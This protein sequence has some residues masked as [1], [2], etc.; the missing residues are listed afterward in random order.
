MILKLNKTSIEIKDFIEKKMVLIDGFPAIQKQKINFKNS[1]EFNGTILQLKTHYF[2]FAYYKPRGTESTMNKNIQNNLYDAT[3]IN[4][5][6]FPVGR[7]DI[8]SEGLMI[9]TN[10][11]NFY[12]TIISPL[13]KVEKEYLVKVDKNVTKEFIKQ[14]KS[15]VV[16][17]GRKTQKCEAEKMGEFD[18][19]I[20]LTEGKNRQIRRMCYKLGFEVLQLKR[21]RIGNLYLE[22]LSSGEFLKIEKSDI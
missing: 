16:I 2:Y 15:G 1:I 10:D 19:K 12:N 22:N 9:L 20:I 3:G 18:F 4:E 7:L 17:M 11:G 13:K 5:V 6:F 14:L 21:I 8:D